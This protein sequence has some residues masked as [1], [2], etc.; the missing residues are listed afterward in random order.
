[1]TNRKKINILLVGL[2]PHAKRI[3]FPIIKTDSKN[4]NARISLIVDLEEKR[5][6]I[7]KYLLDAGEKI[8]VLYLSPEQ[9]TYDVLTKEIKNI[10]DDKIKKLNINAI[11]ISTEPLAHIVYAKYAL[12][13]GLHI[14]MDK[15][16]STKENISTDIKRAKEI[17][18]DY[19]KLVTLHKKSE[20]NTAIK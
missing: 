9:K 3:Y 18:T 11:F 7:E 19:K 17:I 12:T 13:R 8:D 20:K 1:M 4:I 14:L 2:G 5:E 10:L 15:P 16:L 6:D